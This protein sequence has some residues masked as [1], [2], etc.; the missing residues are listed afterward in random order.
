MARARKQQQSKPE[1]LNS[2][3]VVLELFSATTVLILDRVLYE[4]PEVFQTTEPGSTCA[5]ASA[6]SDR[7]STYHATDKRAESAS[8]YVL[9]GGYLSIQRIVRGALTLHSARLF[10]TP[11]LSLM[12]PTEMC[13]GRTVYHDWL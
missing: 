2:L 3:S 8:V 6:D 10:M 11:I 4:R 12:R 9:R 5:W 13:M 7:P 1:P